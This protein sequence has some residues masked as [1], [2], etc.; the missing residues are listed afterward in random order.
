MAQGA[1]AAAKAWDQQAL[2]ESESRCRALLDSSLDC[3]IWTD[4]QGRIE[5]FNSAAERTF[6]VS[7]ATVLGKDLS[8]TI[9]PSALR[10]HL[11]GELF[12]SV[13]SSGIE[14]AGNRL[15]TKAMRADESEFPAELTVT[16]AIIKNKTNFIV[17]VRDITARQR[18]EEA[19]VR[20]AAI[21]ESSQDAI[22]GTDLNRQITSWNKGAEI[23]YGYSAEEAIGQDISV[24][25]PSDRYEETIRIRDEAKAGRQVKSFETV[26]VAKNGRRLDVSLS[27]SPVLDSD[28]VVVGSS[29][30]G[31]DITV[32]K[33][34][35]EALR[36]ANET[37]IYA[38]PVPII[39]VD[40]ERHVTMWNPAARS[41]FGWSEEEVL[42]K[43]NPITL[44]GG[45]QE[46]VALHKRAL[47]GETLTGIELHGRKRDGSA[48]VIS[49]S[50]TPLRD[51]NQRIRGTIGFL[52]DITETKRAEETLR[53]TEQKYRNIFEN[54]IEGIYQATPQGKYLS[55]NPAL[56][57]ML[58]F[59]SPEELIEARSDIRNQEYVHPDMHEEFVSLMRTQGMVQNFEYQAYRKDGKV[60]WVSAN[61][62]VVRDATGQMVYVEGTVQDTTERREL[63][64][65]LRQM[66]KIEAVGRL[67]GGVAHDFNNILMAISS[68]AELLQIR[69]K[70]NDAGRKYLDEIGRAVDRAASLTQGLLTF[71]RK[72]V[73]S[74][75]VLELNTV[76][77]QQLKMLRRLVPENIELDFVRG[78][79]LECVKA[80]PAQIE[81]VV[82]N[83]VI[84]ARDAMPDGG[85]VLIE[86]GNVEFNG[87]ASSSRNQLS[88]N[89]L[90]LNHPATGKYVMIAVSDSGCGMDAIT[91]AQIFE[92]FFTTKETGKGTGL[93]LA[94]VLGIVKQ[95]LGHILVESEPG[96]GTSFNIYLPRVDSAKSEE[97]EE[98]KD[99]SSH[100]TETIL[101]V[102]DEQGV[103]EATAEYL[104]QRG[105]T[106][107]T[108][109]GGPQ[110][111]TLANQFNGTIHLMLT[112][113]VMPQMSGHELSEKITIIHPET[114]VVF[115]SGYANNL[116]STHQVLDPG[117]VLLQKPIRLPLLS[118]RL[119]EILDR[120]SSV[121]AGR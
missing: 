9:L 85:K 20:L 86:T 11:R 4:E 80:D 102:E 63:E 70:Q 105:Y 106:V 116:L 44:K 61:A 118:R 96:R 88:P 21:V 108:A 46:A 12:A 87:D 114:R 50:A 57:R 115:M 3:I 40:S 25:S 19:L 110:A 26:R 18:A 17:Y 13:A 7:R 59:A 33:Q 111:L 100:A 60:I 45:T 69:I 38:S 42:G 62:H 22:I 103:R 97:I 71:S 14:L 84:N 89:D 29:A 99:F 24:L 90:S 94:I 49:L 73:L 51:E 112:D 107:L 43:R 15:E 91:R 10:P 76:I 82:M 75:K 8:A 109:N 35:Q 104:K 79:A 37:S 39:A 65:Q 30:I 98:V 55:A 58:G 117:H 47:A 83:L 41:V 77:T 72:Q 121:S 1:K 113:V 93:G 56:A 53:R 28:G 64:Q 52:T 48:V 78:D 34:A 92:P 68:Y 32:Q 119:R 81:Q 67:A 27:I 36:K 101:L 74:P 95:S 2:E 54:A 66:Q 120:S 31:R 5:E 16:T 6:R 23:M